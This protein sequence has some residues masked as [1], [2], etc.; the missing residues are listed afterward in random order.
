MQSSFQ[1][2]N[3]VEMQA[4]QRGPFFAILG[5]TSRA[6]CSRTDGKLEIY[7]DWCA[8]SASYYTECQALTPVIIREVGNPNCRRIQKIHG[9]CMFSE[10][11][12]QLVLIDHR[13]FGKWFPFIKLL[14]ARSITE[15]LLFLTIADSWTG[16]LVWLTMSF[17]ETQTFYVLSWEF[18]KKK[19]KII[20]NVNNEHLFIYLF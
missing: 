20:N 13:Q 16:I 8:I 18:W 2:V 3:I 5:K 6:E 7:K 9:M 12:P 17:N 19:K 15:K 4:E 14:T 11:M 10:R 1:F